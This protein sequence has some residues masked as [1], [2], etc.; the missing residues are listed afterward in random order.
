MKDQLH[1]ENAKDSEYNTD[2]IDKPSKKV[3]VFHSDELI[4][5]VTVQEMKTHSDSDR[6]EDIKHLLSVKNKGQESSQ[7]QQQ[8]GSKLSKHALRVMERTKLKIQGKKVKRSSAKNSGGGGSGSK[9]NK[10][11]RSR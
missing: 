4:S 9:R 11:R 7:S 3:K 1:I 8:S 6:D 5:T 2:N 10:D